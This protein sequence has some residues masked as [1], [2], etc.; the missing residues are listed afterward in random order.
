MTPALEVLQRNGIE[1]ETDPRKITQLPPYAKDL[2]DMLLNFERVVPFNKKNELQSYCKLDKSLGD[3]E[4]RAPPSIYCDSGH[5]AYLARWNAA[6]ALRDM[7]KKLGPIDSEH[8]WNGLMS[9]FV[10]QDINNQA[11]DHGI[12]MTDLLSWGSSELFTNAMPIR[13]RLEDNNAH[14]PKPDFWF[15]L[16]LYDDEQLSRLKGFELADNN[17]QYFAQKSLKE[18]SRH[19]DDTFVYQPVKSKE[20]AAFPWMVGELKPEDGNEDIC[21]RQAA[22][23]SHTCAV[24]CEQLARLAATDGLPIVAFTSIG[25]QA[26]VFIT[27]NFGTAEDQCYRMSC[28]W[29]GHIRNL[30]H[31]I[32]LRCIVDRLLFWALRFFK[33]WVAYCLERWHERKISK[34]HKRTRNLRDDQ[35]SPTSSARS[36]LL[37]DRSERN[38]SSTPGTGNSPKKYT[39]PVPKTRRSKSSTSQVRGRFHKC[40]QSATNRSQRSYSSGTE[41]VRF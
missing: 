23:A 26:K 15:G 7:A 16:G 10:F 17:I 30:L 2:R 37:G 38:Y 6:L 1:I 34:K 22:N 21:L 12:P 35:S 24:L 36:Q 5:P 9:G 41:S 19:L 4:Y 40:K 31:A 18:T 13:G 3:T 28:I 33:P 27:Y 11:S 8:K 32:Q 14:Q 39:L 25:P 29:S 20:N